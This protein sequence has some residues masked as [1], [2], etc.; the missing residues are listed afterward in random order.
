M[1]LELHL[2]DLPDVPIALGSAPRPA[3]RVHVAWHQRLRE[4]LA[5]YLPLLLILVALIVRGVAFEFRSKKSDPVWRKRWD[6]AIVVSSFVP[7]LLW[8]VAFANIVAGV[9]MEPNPAGGSLFT[10]NLFT[11]L[12]P[13]GLL[14]GVTTLQVLVPSPEIMSFVATVPFSVPS[15]TTRAIRRPRP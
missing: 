8:G 12:N 14:G 7:A 5:T 13:Y 6:A 1:T 4:L 3:P 2:P 9:P 10:G 15:S 11:L